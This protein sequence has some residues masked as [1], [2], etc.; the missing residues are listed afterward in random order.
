[1]FAVHTTQATLP[2]TELGRSFD[3]GEQDHLRALTF[4]GAA[5]RQDFF[6]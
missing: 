4:E 2:A 1:M 5:K 6:G 3:V